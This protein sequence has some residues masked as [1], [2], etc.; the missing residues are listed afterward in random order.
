[1]SVF[2]TTDPGK[3]KLSLQKWAA[4]AIPREARG[5][6][7][8]VVKAVY[9]KVLE[10]SPVKEGKFRKNTKLGLNMENVSVD[11]KPG[12]NPPVSGTPPRGDEWRSSGYGDVAKGFKMGD[13][14]NVSNSVPHARK[15]EYVGWG[16]TG[17]Y[18]PF[19]TAVAWVASDADRAVAYG[20]RR[21]RPE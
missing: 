3:F 5:N 10:N 20:K 11:D 19:E 7:L 2:T 15:V 1:M 17:P 13:T 4:Q 8:A 6:T 9:C 21:G 12:A 18:A 14:V 16:T